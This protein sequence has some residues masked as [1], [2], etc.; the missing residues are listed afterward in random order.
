MVEIEEVS[1]V[2]AAASSS[3]SSAEDHHIHRSKYDVFLSFQGEDTGKTFVDHL[4]SALVRSGIYT[5]KDDERLEIGE[6][7]SPALLKAIEESSFAVV[8]FS[9]NYAYSRWCLDELVKIME[10]SSKSPKGQTVIP[11]FYDVVPSD[12]RKQEG[13][14]GQMFCKHNSDKVQIWRKALTDAANLSGLELNKTADGHESKFI[15][16]IVQEIWSKLSSKIKVEDEGLVGM[17]S[18]IEKVTLLL[19]EESNVVR[20]I[21]IWGLSGIGKSTLAKAVYH[22]IKDQFEVACFLDVGEA[23]KDGLR[24]LQQSLLSRTLGLK[25]LQIANDMDGIDLMKTRLQS[26]RVLLVLDDVV[27]SEQLE[28]LA[29]SHEWFGLG[30]RIIITTRDRDLVEH[31][32]EVQI[33][34]ASLLDSVEA[35]KLFRWKVFNDMCPLKDS[36]ELSDQVIYYC[37]GLPLALEVLGSALRGKNLDFWKDLLEKLRKVG[38]HGD[39]HKKLKIGFDDLEEIVKNTFLDIACF[40]EGWQKEYVTRILYS[41]GF[42]PNYSIHILVL[43]S[44]IHCSNGKVCMHQLIREMGRHIVRQKFPQEPGKYSRLWD[45]SNVEHV[46]TR[47]TGTENIEG[48]ML[49]PHEQEYTIEMGTKA[50]RKMTKLRLLE[51]HNACIPKGPD[52]LPDELR[53]IDWDEYPSNSLPAMFEANVLVGLRLRCSRLKQLWDGRTKK[54]LKN[55]KY[56]D[57]SDSRNLVGISHLGEACNL[58]EL[59][60]QRCT[61]LVKVDPSI[62]LLKKLVCLNLAGCEK[63]RSLPKEMGNLECLEELLLDETAVTELPP[64]IGYLKNLKKLSLFKCSSQSRTSIFKSLF[65]LRKTQKTTRSL[66]LAPIWGLTSLTSLDLTG[67]NLFEGVIPGDIGS[68]F[69]LKKLCLGGNN[70]ENLPSLNQLSQLAH[71]ELSGCKML[72]ELPELPSRLNR[73]FANDCASLSV[74]ADRFAMC[75]IEYGW[76]LD[77]RK[78]LDSKESEIVANTLLQQMLQ[79]AQE[80][81]V[82]PY[83]LISENIIL[84]GKS[85]SRVVLQSHFYGRFSFVEVSSHFYRKSR[86]SRVV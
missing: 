36:K 69:S 86:Y 58:E 79:Y 35:T 73:L 54:L 71:L 41:F 77:C 25:D 31:K 28:K 32:D 23:S 50:F 24:C 82:W 1:E 72:R 14:F 55:L 18:R 64:S 63:L 57:L 85:Y 68:M 20:T 12:V 22:Q 49:H 27:S 81:L 53:W 65:Q 42:Y 40:F 83:F 61:S 84:P 44:L 10:C 70:F 80:N 7:I 60:L 15:D 16:R 11:V 56:V 17:K 4:Y 13:H 2:E 5:F 34:D 51:I 59:I 43:K 78:L 62:A 19:G 39:I 45:T 26:R 3:S 46:L 75:K 33:Y 6:S 30:S 9:K 74:S 29:G 21:G 48:I 47:S 76:F 8:V 66:L 67:C 37:D 38:L 52:Y